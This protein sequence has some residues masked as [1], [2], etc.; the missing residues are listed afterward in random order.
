MRWWCVRI[1]FIYY[2]IST[3]PVFFFVFFFA[4]PSLVVCEC[5]ACARHRVIYS[6][7]INDAADNMQPALWRFPRQRRRTSR[8]HHYFLLITRQANAFR[9]E[10]CSSSRCDGGEVEEEEEE[11]EDWSGSSCPASRRAHTDLLFFFF[12]FTSLNWRLDKESA[13]AFL[14][15]MRGEM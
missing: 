8:Q 2:F 13:L 7:Q 5:K 3:I 9:T 12:F 1:W 10:S 6:Q 15:W 11:E 14:I 4:R